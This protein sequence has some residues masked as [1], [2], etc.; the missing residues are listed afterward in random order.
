MTEHR[1]WGGQVCKNVSGTQN[2]KWPVTAWRGGY[3]EIKKFALMLVS[4]LTTKEVE[5]AGANR[6]L[7]GE[8]Q[9]SAEAR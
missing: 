4:S 6:S 9:V 7:V 3:G 5:K 1:E 8:I 2:R